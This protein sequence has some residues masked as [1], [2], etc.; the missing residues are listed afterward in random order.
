MQLH[1]AE[2][3]FSSVKSRS[4]STIP[5]ITGFNWAGKTTLLKSLLPLTENMPACDFCLT[6]TFGDTRIRQEPWPEK[7]ECVQ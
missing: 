2:A 3:I 4:Y 5:S 1:A 7:A 6:Q